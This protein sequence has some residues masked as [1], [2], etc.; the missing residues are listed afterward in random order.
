MKSVTLTSALRALSIVVSIHTLVKSVT[1]ELRRISI[2]MS[3]SIHTLVKSVTRWAIS[4]PLA[5][6][7]FQSTRS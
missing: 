6:Q 1:P 2:H 7:L 3:V 5:K 4:S